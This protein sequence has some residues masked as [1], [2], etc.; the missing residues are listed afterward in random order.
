MWKSPEGDGEG[1]R[2]VS[3]R[4][5]SRGK[6]VREKAGGSTWRFESKQKLQFVWQ[7]QV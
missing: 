5:R 3:V 7:S 4:D 1:V 6:R 2:M